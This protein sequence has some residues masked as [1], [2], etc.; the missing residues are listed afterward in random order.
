VKRVDPGDAPFVALSRLVRASSSGGA[1]DGARAAFLDRATRRRRPSA[2][3]ATVAVVSLA[4]A[5]VVVLRRPP[6]APLAPLTVTGAPDAPL[7]GPGTLI[8]FGD[9]SELDLAPDGRGRLAEVTPRGAHLVLEEGRVAVRVTPRPGARWRIEAGPFTVAVT[10]TSF[11]VHWQSASR[12][13]EIA[14]S[15]GKVLVTGPHFEQALAAGQRLVATA[16]TGIVSLGPTAPPPAPPPPARPAPKPAVRHL[17]TRIAPP[18]AP[19]DWSRLVAHGEFGS[20]VAD[21]EAEGI[22]QVLRRR[23]LPEIEALATAARLARR[24]DLA[25]RILGA[26]R[27]RFPG[28]P[29]AQEAAFH[30]GRLADDQDLDPSAAVAWY[31]RYLAESPGGP[32]AAEARGRRM[33]ALHRLHA[34][35]APAAARDYLAHHPTGPHATSARIILQS[36]P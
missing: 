9:G 2:L 30:L 20:V 7:L 11:Q 10:G 36:L 22:D 27:A 19:P 28:A 18:I 8:R 12:R 21:A 34:A 32:L 33:L 31:D 16:D 15:S 6:P 23:S 25:V 26:T 3:L 5:A 4:V 24:T 29:A 17:A 1:D 35:T 14:M 13:F